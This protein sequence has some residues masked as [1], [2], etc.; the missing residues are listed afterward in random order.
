MGGIA[1]FTDENGNL[2]NFYQCVQ[3]KIYVKE[4][5]G[6]RQKKT[7]CFEKIEPTSPVEIRRKT[8]NLLN[9]IKECNTVAFKEI[10]G[11]PFTVFDK[12][13]CNVFSIEDNTME[14]LAEIENDILTLQEERKK[15]E[16]LGSSIAPVETDIPG[17]YFFDLMKAQEKYPELTSKKVLKPFFDTVPFMELSLICAHMPP[18]LERDPRFKIKTEKKG[19]QLHLSIT[20]KQC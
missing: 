11:I 9:F 5:D 14:Q 10:F 16:E 8:E 17:V 3:I 19:L 18:W 1:V 13:G 15:R 7:I 6:F 4:K 12:A 20:Y 2:A